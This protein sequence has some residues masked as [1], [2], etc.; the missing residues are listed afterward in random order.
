MSKDKFTRT[1]AASIILT[2]ICLP[3]GIVPLIYS[4]KAASVRGSD[5]NAYSRCLNISWRWSVVGIVIMVIIYIV[6][7]IFL[8][9]R[10]HD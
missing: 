7:A 2:C 5:P 10:L 8:F 1:L 3:I 9:S 6:A 4:I